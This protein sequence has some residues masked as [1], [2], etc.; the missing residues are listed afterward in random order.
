MSMNRPKHCSALLVSLLFLAACSRAEGHVLDL[1]INGK[2]ACTV[3][4]TESDGVAQIDAGLASATL[5]EGSKIELMSRPN[6]KNQTFSYAYDV[7]KRG[8]KWQI[9]FAGTTNNAGEAAS[10]TELRSLIARELA[11]FVQLH[12][13]EHATP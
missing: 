7:K 1:T 3:D 5:A 9:V 11:S 13:R 6:A 4:V 8:T 12:K 10:I 2:H